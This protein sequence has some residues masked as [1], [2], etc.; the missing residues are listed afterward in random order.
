MPNM[1][2]LDGGHNTLDL[3]GGGQGAEYAGLDG[4]CRIHRT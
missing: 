3:T 1:S 2:D 4:V